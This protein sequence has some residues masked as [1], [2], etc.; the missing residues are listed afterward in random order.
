MG[1]SRKQWA[2]LLPLIRAFTNGAKIQKLGYGGRFVDVEEL[3]SVL[4]CQHRL[5]PKDLKEGT[6]TIDFRSSHK[7]YPDAVVS[8][9]VRWKGSDKD[10][11]PWRSGN[12]TGTTY[13]R[14]TEKFIPDVL[15]EVYPDPEDFYTNGIEPDQGFENE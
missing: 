15:E 1:G 3:T 13:L 5:K 8:G 14:D 11:P 10:D 4:Y 9:T 12:L 7:E 2:S 6:W